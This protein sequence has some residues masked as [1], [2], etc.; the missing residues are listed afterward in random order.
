MILASLFSYAYAGLGIFEL[1]VQVKDGKLTYIV[2]HFTHIILQLLTG[3]FFWTSFLYKEEL[4]ALR[5]WLMNW[6]P[7]SYIVEGTN[8]E[9]VFTCLHSVKLF[10]TKVL[11]VESDFLVTDLELKASM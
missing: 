6:D 11:E 2:V 4:V 5:Q 1:G 9:R 8:Q 10:I 3:T 7:S